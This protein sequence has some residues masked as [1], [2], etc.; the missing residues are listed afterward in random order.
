[1]GPRLSTAL[2]S[3][4]PASSVQEPR[5]AAGASAASTVQILHCGSLLAVT[6]MIWLVRGG[7]RTIV[8]LLAV[9]LAAVLGVCAATFL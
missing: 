1:M 6:F 9:L 4:L 8:W 3:V 5:S 2:L 7:A